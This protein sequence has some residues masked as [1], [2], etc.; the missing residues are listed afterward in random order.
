VLVQLRDKLVADG[1]CFN[2]HEANTKHPKEGEDVEVRRSP[3]AVACRERY[4]WRTREA[5]TAPNG[6]KL[7]GKVYS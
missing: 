6:G 5:P 4:A 7:G 2:A 1:E 3:Q